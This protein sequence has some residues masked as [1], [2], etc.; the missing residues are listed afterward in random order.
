MKIY[1]KLVRDKIPQIIEEDDKVCKIHI[2]LQDE[3]IEALETKL[4]EEVSE[5][6]Q[7]KNLEEL[8]DVLEVLQSIC[9]ARGHSLEQLEELRKKKLDE[10][11]G[12]RDRIFLEYVE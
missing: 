12:F 8:A 5:Y 1:N 9:I 11:G 4:L 2:L 10:R 7:D 3:Y 6:Q